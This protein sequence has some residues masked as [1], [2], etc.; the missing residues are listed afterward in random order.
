MR[1]PQWE[2]SESNGLPLGAAA[3]LQF[4]PLAA[5]IIDLS[6]VKAGIEEL[7][8]SGVQDI[9]NHIR[10]H[11]DES[12]RLLSLGAIRWFN[13]E[14]LRTFGFIEP[15]VPGSYIAERLGIEGIL[16][17]EHI[18][19][20]LI[21]GEYTIDS[22]PATFTSSSGK[23]LSFRIRVVRGD[24]ADE[25]WRSVL[26]YFSAFKD[27]RGRTLTPFDAWAGSRQLFRNMTIGFSLHEMI[28]D[29]SGSPSDYRFIFVNPSYE[30]MT[31]LKRAEIIGRRA[32]S[33]LP[34]TDLVLMATYGEVVRTGKPI[35]FQT[36]SPETGRH[37]EV[38]AY[39]PAAGTFVTLIQDITERL[40]DEKALAERE[41]LLGAILETTEEG[42]FILDK[43]ARFTATNEAG[44][45]LL[46]YSREELLG[47]ELPQICTEA[48]LNRIGAKLE[49]IRNTGHD[50]FESQYRHKS[51]G[52]FDVEVSSSFLNEDGG[53]YIIFCQDISER[54]LTEHILMEQ[55]ERLALALGGTG[56][57]L[58][59]WNMAT[60]E[61]I[62][63]PN[64]A[65]MLGYPPE[66]LAG[67]KK[68]KWEE[69]CHPEDREASREALARHLA[70][71]T[72][73]Y[74]CELRVKHKAGHWSWVINQGELVERDAEGKPLRMIGLMFDISAQKENE[75]QLRV[76]LKEKG[77]LLSELYHRTKNSM[78]LINAM[79]ELKK[80]EIGNEEVFAAFDDIQNKILAMALVQEKLYQ[81]DRLDSID[82]GSYVSDLMELFES[83]MPVSPKDISFAAEAGRVPVSA[84]IAIPCGIIISELIGNS[85]SH[86][87]PERGKGSIGISVYRSPEGEISI[88]QWDDGVGL[89][90]G[91]DPRRSGRMGLKTIIGIGEEQLHGRISFGGSEKGFR[92][93]LSFKD[94]YYPKR[95]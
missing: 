46:G 73:R 85:V 7:R 83:E 40:R 48:C 65:K 23:R 28:F 41:H 30:K 25:G 62:L 10:S 16:A 5:A 12:A 11:Q 79:L 4:L 61:M 15:P 2:K 63:D 9:E 77:T 42:F 50:R 76:A 71:E 92:C 78:Q 59:D 84:D 67:I 93:K 80:Q 49:K 64:W 90:E 82:L 68:D 87:F 69:I 81:S 6:A 88:E 29:D 95:V 14:A 70:G 44:C 36:Y 45:R 38:R 34:R 17:F 89:P 56:T 8:Q 72:P 27:G 33:V 22:P 35:C 43:N 51:G 75:R 66:E 57:C 13:E 94:I 74:S 24:R 19:F 21:A 52:I 53:K 31:G 58:W 26:L 86:A 32:S 37:F 60:G 1:D 55:E 47:M 54:K 3:S 39:R 20:G 18:V 91:F